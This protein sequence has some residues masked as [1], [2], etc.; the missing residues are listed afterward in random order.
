MLTD[1]EIALS[2]LDLQARGRDF[3][4]VEIPAYVVW[5]GRK[6][7]EG[8]SPAL[9]A[10]LDSIAMFL[11]PEEVG[12]ITDDIFEELLADLKEETAS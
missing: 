6:I 3:A 4:L 9:V 5:S 11:L 1:R 7:G 8:E 2:S 12:T 10:H